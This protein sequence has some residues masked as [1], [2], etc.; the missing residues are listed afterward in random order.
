MFVTYSSVVGHVKGARLR[1]L[2]VV[3]PQRIQQTPDVPTM[4]EQGFDMVVGSW[5]G[6]YLPKGTPKAVA[7]RLFNATHEAMKN[8]DVNKRLQDGGVTV[9]TSSSPAEFRTFWEKENARFA[10][11]IKDA[12]IPPE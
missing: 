4:R 1:M 6:V 2:A 7:N 5:Q 9:I 8:A 10:Q 11:V 3:T 12:K